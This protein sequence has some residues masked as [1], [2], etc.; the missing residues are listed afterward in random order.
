MHMLMRTI[1][2]TGWPFYNGGKEATDAART[3]HYQS[4]FGGETPVMICT[5]AFSTGNDYANV[6]LVVHM[7]MPLE[8]TELIQAQGRGGRDG[9]PAKCYMLPALTHGKISI[10]RDELDHKGLWYAR[11][12]ISDQGEKRCLRH[13]STLYVDGVGACCK[14]DASNE[15]CSLC[16]EDSQEA[17]GIKQIGHRQMPSMPNMK[18]TIQEGAVGPVLGRGQ[19]SSMK[20]AI[21]EISAEDEDP[22]IEVCQQAKKARTCRL[23][24]ELLEVDRMR[25][26]LDKIKDKG[27]ALC[28]TTS[29][30]AKIHVIFQ[31]PTFELLEVSCQSYLTWKKE[32]KYKHHK[33]ICWKCHV[34]TCE[35]KLHAPLIT[36]K[37]NCNWPDI[38]IP[39]AF[40]IFSNDGLN[41]RAGKVFKVDWKK[42]LEVFA[43]WLSKRP[44]TGR[45][46]NGMDLLLWFADNMVEIME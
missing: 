24:E 46:S 25:T 18:T 39:I 4:W 41:A 6:R 19:M 12:Y 14:D 9:Q 11:D 8:M 26:A 27:C 1:D 35:G 42:D 21:E 45:L 34:P 37:A 13:R 2:K 28:L 44:A 10:G 3:S 5:S 30:D 23:E 31:C 29:N 36:R 17:V 15:R 38:V 40:G 43:A 32:I 22:F 7:K 16:K 33:G 20:R